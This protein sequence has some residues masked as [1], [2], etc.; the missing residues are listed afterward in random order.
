MKNIL[1]LHKKEGQTPLGALENFKKKNPEYRGV[2]LTYAGRLDPM[3]SGVLLVLA[4]KAIANKEKYL[5]LEKEYCFKLLFG[6]ATDTHDIL[7]KVIK[8]KI[9]K[10]SWLKSQDILKKKLKEISQCF[11]GEIMQEY[12]NYSSKTVNGKALFVYAREKKLVK[13]PSHQ[14][15]IKKL[16]FGDVKK[17]KPKRLY[18]II[19][20]RIYRVKGDFRQR[21]ILKIWKRVLMNR[22][23]QIVYIMDARIVCSS[24]TYIRKIAHDIGVQIKI[25]AL[26]WNIT[27][28]RV[29]KFK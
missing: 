11:I 17:M 2:S 25:P 10:E 13:V 5:A 21:E 12:P 1:V 24:G 22:N 18:S 3:A 26:A 15:K 6:Y 4:G 7:G 20:K 29:G 28:T 19:E 27:R 8:K 16:S 9:S 14:V 23:A